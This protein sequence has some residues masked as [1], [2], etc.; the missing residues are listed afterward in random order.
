MA[1]ADHSEFEEPLGT[2]ND[3]NDEDLWEP[4][5]PPASSAS[6]E[7]SEGAEGRWSSLRHRR[8]P[9]PSAPSTKP[10]TSNR[11]SSS[12]T[13]TPRSAYTAST[14]G[15]T[16]AS[17]K[18]DKNNSLRSGSSSSTSNIVS[19]PMRRIAGRLC[20][21]L[22]RQ[23]WNLDFWT[24]GAIVCGTV[25]TF[26]QLLYSI[27]YYA[28]YPELA[29]Y[30][31]G[32]LLVAATP[33][34]MYGKPALEQL[35]KD[36][37]SSP[38]DAIADWINRCLDSQQMRGLVAFCLFVL[39]AL[40]EMRTLQF[41]SNLV[42][43]SSVSPPIIFLLILI[44]R[45]AHSAWKRTGPQQRRPSDSS[46]METIVLNW[47]D[48][49]PHTCF[50]FALYALYGL[51]LWVVLVGPGSGTGS[52]RH[53]PA[54]AGRF[55]LA[56]AVLLYQNSTADW[57]R[58]VHNALRLTVRDALQELGSSVQEDELL[59]LTMLRWLVE[60]WSSSTSSTFS[61][62]STTTHG[63]RRPTKRTDAQLDMEW[64]ELWSMLQVTTNQMS[65]EVEQLHQQL[66][67]KTQ[68]CPIGNPVNN[69]PQKTGSSAGLP[70]FGSFPPNTGAEAPLP[71]TSFS[72]TA[73]VSTARVSNTT[74]TTS[75][76]PPPS[77]REPADDPVHK[78]QLMLASINIDELAKPAVLAYKQMVESLPPSQRT[79][80][81]L[82]LVRRC[83]ALMLLLAYLFLGLVGL[84]PASGSAVIILLP[85]AGLDAW[86]VYLWVKACK[87]APPCSANATEV[88]RV[89]KV[90]MFDSSVDSMTILLMDDAFYAPQTSQL[91]TL[92]L[93]WKNV[94]ASVSALE[95][96]LTAT[97][98]VQ[99]SVVAVDFTA[100]IISLV[101]LG[102]E[103]S[104]HGWRHGVMVVARELLHL[105]TTRTD[106]TTLSHGVA[107]P[108]G[109]SYT[110]AAVSAVRNSQTL[111]RN[112]RALSEE[113]NV[114]RMMGPMLAFFPLLIGHGWIW[115]GSN[116]EMIREEPIDSQ[117]VN[118]STVEII[119][120]DDEAD[121]ESS[122]PSLAGNKRIFDD[123][124]FGG[125]ANDS[126]S[127]QSSICGQMNS[128]GLAGNASD[129]CA[130][131]V[132]CAP[133]QDA[134]ISHVQRKGTKLK[135]IPQ[136]P[137]PPASELS[138]DS[139]DT[140]TMQ[141]SVA[142]TFKRIEQPA[143]KVGKEIAAKFEKDASEL[144][145]LL[146]YCDE[147][148]VIEQVSLTDDLLMLHEVILLPNFVLLPIVN[149]K[150]RTKFLKI[151]RG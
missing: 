149:R 91:P 68:E 22:C 106:L 120:L 60:Y 136:P 27:F 108:V 34:F 128:I 72:S 14:R 6:F 56:T 99:T 73:D 98:C 44:G 2:S 92:L 84:H 125:Q 23:I 116:T 82:A 21:H 75:S 100:N 146:S 45:A 64:S 87:L 69:T 148:S 85:F 133:L 51:A 16:V 103:I 88:E 15:T 147:H 119:E 65:T 95:V 142:A 10:S 102:L 36:I 19:H 141:G 62:N 107:A 49:S 48:L 140:T 46:L 25:G 111:N 132:A 8:K 97:R 96:G 26:F 135:G 38:A 144:M 127:A 134:A 80:T 40:L 50:H 66:D 53:V 139:V 9:D 86:N 11:G 28:F 71:H 35:L 58:A 61:K 94:C 129:E 17:R 151:L 52:W 41:L 47:G 131:A 137:V 143:N 54:L 43:G 79:A 31:T 32:L 70:P 77:Q 1:D 13:L 59:Q 55:G 114:G 122:D 33:L 7:N 105:H 74:N 90:W 4:L 123:L 126:K 12:K 145:E 117:S 115:G 37:D 104:E 20:V 5:V 93:V 29:L 101:N 63:S 3:G 39:P 76:I 130:P 18:Q 110:S 138:T 124:A 42:G 89:V 113:M 83:P 81:A 78:L 67:L 121:S 57:S 24:R 150:K 30:T 109:A 118:Q 112:F